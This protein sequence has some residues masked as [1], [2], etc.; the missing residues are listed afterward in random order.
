MSGQ[1]LVTLAHLHKCIINYNPC[2]A[3]MAHL[4]NYRVFITHVWPTWLTSIYNPCLAN[5]AHLTNYRVSGPRRLGWA[6]STTSWVCRCGSA[7][8]GS[9]F[10]L[11]S[12]QAR[13]WGY[14]GHSRTPNP[15]DR[16]EP[17]YQIV[18]CLVLPRAACLHVT[19]LC[20]HATHK[21]VHT[22]THTHARADCRGLLGVARSQRRPHGCVLAGAGGQQA[23]G[24]RGGGSEPGR[25]GACALMCVCVCVRAC[26]YVCVRV[27]CHA[28]QG[29]GTCNEACYEVQ[30][31]FLARWQAVLQPNVSA[32][33]LSKG[34]S[35]HPNAPPVAA[36]PGQILAL[37]WLSS[38]SGACQ[39]MG[40]R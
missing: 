29:D 37:K 17:T 26:V 32:C 4:T 13:G 28:V 15:Y 21:H 25:R 31:V 16:L 40:G 27:L 10:S 18:S 6:T 36:A 3:N 19:C 34:A 38:A 24:S 11:S 22:H 12:W 20:P 5:M 2:L 14:Q 35:R 23:A 8:A 1:L 30:Q 33:V 7:V 9:L 39:K